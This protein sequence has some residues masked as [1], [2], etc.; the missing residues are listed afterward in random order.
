VASEV[1]ILLSWRGQSTPFSDWL[2]SLRDA[3][4]VV[5]SAH[6]SIGSVLL[7]GGDKRRQARDILAAQKYWK[8][9]MPKQAVKTESYRQGLLESLRN[10]EEAA[11]YLNA[12]L[13]DE[14]D[15]VFLLGLRDVADSH[16]GI[17]ALSRDTYLNRKAFIACSPSPAI[18]RWTA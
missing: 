8:G 13:E 15:R 2:A 12:C 4:T 1:E 5:L 14:D 11:H 9:S 16:G 18:H 3:R 17:R 10:P 7:C 6:G